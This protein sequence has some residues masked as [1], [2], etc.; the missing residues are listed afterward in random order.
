MTDPTQPAPPDRPTVAEA[1]ADLVQMFV[2]YVRQ[3]TDDIVREKVVLPTQVAGQVVA[4]A[5]AAAMVLFLGIGYISV[6]ALM[7]LASYV[8]W[9]A[10]LAIVGTL[11]II[12][13]AVLTYAK[14]RKVQK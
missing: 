5:L 6:A 1:I 8:G 2:D 4:F 11:L 9:P 7:V 3:E 14:M 12:G 10:A 13:A